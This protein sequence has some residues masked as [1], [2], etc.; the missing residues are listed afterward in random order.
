[1][2]LIHFYALV[3]PQAIS[4][5][6]VSFGP[7]VCLWCL[8]LLVV[9]RSDAPSL[10]ASSI[11]LCSRIWALTD[12]YRLLLFAYTRS[13][14]MPSLP[15]TIGVLSIFMNC[16]KNFQKNP[17]SVYCLQKISSCRKSSLNLGRDWRIFFQHIIFQHHLR[18]SH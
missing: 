15:F 8:V 10:T 13:S 17:Q 12:G 6:N 18:Q 5:A 2:S 7:L 3:Q 4:G 1:M 9:E 16:F 14:S 11:T